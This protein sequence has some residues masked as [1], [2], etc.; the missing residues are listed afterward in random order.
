MFPPELF[1]EKLKLFFKQVAEG[2][3]RVV[4]FWQSFAICG[5]NERS[6]AKFL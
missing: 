1:E 2:I 3:L 6:S 4:L 5:L